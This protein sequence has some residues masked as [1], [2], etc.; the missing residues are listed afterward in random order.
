MKK[1]KIN[2]LTN[3]EDYTK[4]EH[5][6]SF[7]RKI[8]I[9]LSVMAVLVTLFFTIISLRQGT[10]LQNLTNQKNSLLLQL[11][12]K[13]D[14]QAQ[15]AYI[16]GKYQLVQNYMKEDAYSLPYYNLLS[17]ALS[18]STESAALASF[19]IQRNR[20]TN[21]SVSFNNFDQLIQ[22][23]K[24]IESD[25]FLKNF[26][27]VSMKSFN[28]ASGSAS[29]ANYTLSFTGRFIPIYETQH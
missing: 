14:A 21:F 13:K 19:V 25:S 11:T 9:L 27:Q 4:L 7:I 12:G 23:L 20:E 18:K 2:L 5:L 28:A 17:N 1:T 3:R 26:E 24:F 16:Q 15:L 8:T 6:F 10:Q 22:F 29:L